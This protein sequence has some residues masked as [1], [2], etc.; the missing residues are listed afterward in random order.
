[1]GDKERVK[2]ERRNVC[3]SHLPLVAFLCGC[4]GVDAT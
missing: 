1:M 4:V 2:E 3:G